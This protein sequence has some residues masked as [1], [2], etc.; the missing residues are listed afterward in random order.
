MARTSTPAPAVSEADPPDLKTEIARL[1]S[2]DLSFSAAARRLLQLNAAA[3]GSANADQA[4]YE[5]TVARAEILSDALAFSPAG[6]LED[7]AHK[8]EVWFVMAPEE[9]KIIEQGTSDELLAFSI[10]SDIRRLLAQHTA[11]E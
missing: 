4:K 6:A 1:T 2:G 11:R 5:K 3:R 7:I 9:A 10:M 8:V